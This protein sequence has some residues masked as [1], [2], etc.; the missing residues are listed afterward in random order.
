MES[1]TAG[2][3]GRYFTPRRH[4]SGGESTPLAVDP[5]PLYGPEPAAGDTHFT[6]ADYVSKLRAVAKPN[7]P[8]WSVLQF[9]TFTSDSR[10]PTPEEMRAPAVMSIVEGAQGIFWWDIGVN[11]LRQFDATTVTV[12]A[13]GGSG[14]T[15]TVR[16][17]A[18]RSLGS[19]PE[20]QLEHDLA[21]AVHGPAAASTNQSAL[22]H[23]CGGCFPGVSRRPDARGQNCSSPATAPLKNRFA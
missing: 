9:F 19:Q 11:G 20:L 14:Y 10:M 18:P 16:L 13:T 12:V 5:Y 6:V 21:L 15:F 3:I 22:N 23:P 7:R 1:D 4:G 17:T 8:V 2:R